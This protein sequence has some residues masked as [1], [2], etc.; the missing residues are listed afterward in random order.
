MRED[1]LKEIKNINSAKAM[2]EHDVPT[3]TLKK[4]ADFFP[5]FFHP[6]FNECV[7]TGKCYEG[8]KKHE[9]LK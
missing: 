5:D 7:E 3:K 1:V 8:V 2:Q 6:A 4:N 9:S